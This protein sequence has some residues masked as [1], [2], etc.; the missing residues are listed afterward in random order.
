[1]KL[2][3]EGK[4][5]WRIVNNSQIMFAKMVTLTAPAKQDQIK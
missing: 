5:N 1:M 4:V 3:R 2:D